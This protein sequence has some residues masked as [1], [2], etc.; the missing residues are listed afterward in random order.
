[1]SMPRT[2]HNS[3]DDEFLLF[4]IGAIALMTFLGSAGLFW[5]KGV[6]WMVEHHI[7]VPGSSHPMFAL[8]GGGGAGLD[9][10]RVGLFVGV[11]IAMIAWAGSASRRA[12]A[13]RRVVG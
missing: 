10:P 7:V 3:D 2:T 8:P 5:S 6:V 9:G 13:S 12:I 4:I 1:M 11:L